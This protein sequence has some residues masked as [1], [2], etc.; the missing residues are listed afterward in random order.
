MER[1][2]TYETVLQ[3][4]REQ[5]ILRIGEVREEGIHPEYVRRL[6][7]TGK[8][9]KVGRGL[10]SLPD[11]E[12]TEHHFYAIAARIVPDGVICLLSAL[13]FHGLTTESPFEMWIA[14]ES[15]AWRPTAR[16][17]IPVRFIRYSGRR[18]TEG[19]E[20]HVLENVSVRIFSPAKTVVDCFV[21]RNKIGLDVALSALKECLKDQRASVE[22]LWRYAKICRVSKIIHPY[23]EAFML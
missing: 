6:H 1:N 19:V 7:H 11:N 9:R 18:F 4:A 16:M 2:K 3:M 13:R 8:L 10:Y 20:E 14:I 12:I 21:H 5:G 17:N 23:I 22:E 15:N